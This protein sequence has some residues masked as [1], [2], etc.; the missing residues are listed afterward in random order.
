MK[1]TVPVHPWA[2]NKQKGKTPPKAQMGFQFQNQQYPINCS[3]IP[4]SSTPNT[5]ELIKQTRKSRTDEVNGMQKH[6]RH[7]RTNKKY[8]RENYVCIW[9]R[10][11]RKSKKIGGSLMGNANE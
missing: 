8:T 6:C 2:G 3:E 5:Q 9:G 11:A 7:C 1:E 4:F 10:L